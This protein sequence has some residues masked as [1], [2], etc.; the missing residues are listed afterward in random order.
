MLA[1]LKAV[2]KIWIQKY[3]QTKKTPKTRDLYFIWHMST[4]CSLTTIWEFLLEAL[5]KNEIKTGNDAI[6]TPTKMELFLLSKEQTY[7]NCLKSALSPWATGFILDLKEFTAEM[8]Q[9]L[10]YSRIQAQN[11]QSSKKWNRSWPSVHLELKLERAPS[12]LI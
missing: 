10:K 5:C 9:Q 3:V 8:R 12:P 1:L 6:K 11:F 7:R 4:D 2:F